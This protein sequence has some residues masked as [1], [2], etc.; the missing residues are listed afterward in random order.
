MLCH[1]CSVRWHRTRKGET[2]EQV[3]GLYGCTVPYLRRM[4]PWAGPYSLPIDEWIVVGVSSPSHGGCSDFDLIWHEVQH[5]DSLD[6][7]CSGYG[8]DADRIMRWNPWCGHG[9]L[10]P[11][12]RLVVIVRCVTPTMPPMPPTA[13]PTPPCTIMNF[14]WHQLVPGDTFFLLAQ[15]FNTTVECLQR[16]NSWANPLNLPVG[17]W[18]VVGVPAGIDCR[19]VTLT[20]HQLMPGDTFFNLAARFGTTV[21]CL[22]AWNSWAVPTNLPVGC[23]VIVGVSAA[24]PVFPCQFRPMWHQLVPGDT[25]FQLAQRFNTTVECLQRLNSWANPL[26]LPVGCWV[27]VGVQPPMDC[28][29]TLNWHQLMPGDTFFNL[30]ARFGTTVACLQEWNSWAVPTNLPVGCWIVVGGTP[31][32][33]TAP[34]PCQFRPMWHQLVPGDTFFLLARRFN[35][36]VECLQRMNSWANPLNL[37][38]GCWVVVGVSA[39]MAMAC[40]AFRWHQIMSGD[41]FFTLAQRFGT[42]VECLQTWNSWAVP[43]NLPIGC[44]LVVGMDP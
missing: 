19:N 2:Y 26:N 40:P 22:Q 14:T 37:P 23:W 13:P 41:T 16:L 43:T 1:D 8:V 21:A 11:G 25:F 33:T 7:I 17:C 24:E 28:N 36:T 10:V 34:F 31:G 42:T 15:R 9:P 4:N 35:T 29:I 12:I 30:A 39:P 38:V 3:A 5:G 18:V 32:G 6:S 20:W 27:V 44:W